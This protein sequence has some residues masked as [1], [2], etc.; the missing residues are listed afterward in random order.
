MITDR[1]QVTEMIIAAKVAKGLKWE[2][3]T[4]L[5]SGLEQRNG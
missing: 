1:N 2:E 3:V 5:P 4:C